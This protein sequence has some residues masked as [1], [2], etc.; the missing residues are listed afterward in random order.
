MENYQEARHRL[1]QARVARD[2]SAIRKAKKEIKAI[3]RQQEALAIKLKKENNG[4]LPIWW[5]SESKPDQTE[6]Q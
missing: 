2:K 5:Y 6:V 1:T 4:F 3:K